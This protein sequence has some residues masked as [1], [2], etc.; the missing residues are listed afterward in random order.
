MYL[1]LLFRLAS[2][3]Q[4]TKEVNTISG[5]SAGEIKVVEHVCKSNESSCH[6]PYNII[7]CSDDA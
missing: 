3:S 1:V 7:A 4:F 2:G 5:I 6:K